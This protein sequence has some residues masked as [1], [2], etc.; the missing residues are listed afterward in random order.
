MEA[1]GWAYADA[2]LMADKGIDIRQVEVPSIIERF[3]V[4]FNPNCNWVFHSESSESEYWKGDCG[5]LWVF[6]TGG[7]VE[8]EVAF[9][10]HCS[11]RVTTK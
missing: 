7:P 3:E 6:M 2:C 1:L 4:D 5:G 9:C 11:K 10:P 8:N